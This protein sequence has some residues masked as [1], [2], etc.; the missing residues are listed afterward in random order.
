MPRP[1][2]QKKKERGFDI[3]LKS[4][5]SQISSDIISSELTS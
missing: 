2:P 4:V 1:P 5:L 3:L